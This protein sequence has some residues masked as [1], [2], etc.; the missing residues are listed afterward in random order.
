[1]NFKKILRVLEV[2]TKKDINL[3]ESPKPINHSVQDCEEGD[4]ELKQLKEKVWSYESSDSE[5]QTAFLKIRQLA[6]EGSTDAQK[7]CAKIY[8]RGGSGW[9]DYQAENENRIYSAGFTIVE[10]DIQKAISYYKLA[11]DQGDIEAKLLL[12]Y[13]YMDRKNYRLDGDPIKQKYAFDLF[14]EC[15][16]HNNPKAMGEV[17]HFYCL[18]IGGVQRDI[19]VGS[20]WLEKAG[21]EGNEY[22]LSL[23]NIFNPNRY[24]KYLRPNYYHEDIL[25]QL[26]KQMKIDN[27]QTSSQE[28]IDN[29]IKYT[30][31]LDLVFC[32]DCTSTMAPLLNTLSNNINRLYEDIS[33]SLEA[34]NGTIHLR[35]RL[36]LFRSYLADGI[37]SMTPTDFYTLP[38]QSESFTMMVRSI[39]AAGGHKTDN[40]YNGGREPNDALESIAYALK[41]NW[42]DNLPENHRI[43]I[44]MTDN[45]AQPIGFNM[46]ST[47]Y[48][49]GMPGNLEEL[50]K[51]WNHE[52]ESGLKH[53]KQQ[54]ILMT[55]DVYPWTRIKEDWKHVIF[56]ECTLQQGLKELDYSD[57]I[58]EIATAVLK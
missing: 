21:K 32:I 55:P 51:Q 9:Y 57:I 8:S 4:N 1:M 58:K 15:A 17:G 3:A 35:V 13:L 54:M 2:R 20:D 24:Y 12:A 42:A 31:G 6:D 18:G 30:Q 56:H 40:E 7:E 39:R 38:I 36:I 34:E 44:V 25:L 5:R 27:G 11:S 45:R 46:A 22:A 16:K 53:R 49:T 47:Y 29:R 41:S 50:E 33:R 23:L 19:E 26:E 52:T 28:F 10:C 37:Y 14:M 43:V 48:P